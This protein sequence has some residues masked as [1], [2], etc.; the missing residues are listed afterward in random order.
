MQGARVH[1]V[2]GHG[3]VQGAECR[4]S[5]EVMGAEVGSRAGAGALRTSHLHRHLA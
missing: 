3:A 2:R 4:G 1:T 5:C